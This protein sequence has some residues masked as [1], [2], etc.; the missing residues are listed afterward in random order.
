MPFLL[1]ILCVIALA[2]VQV[3]Y[4]GL[5]RPVFTVPAFFLL[6]L[7][8]VL[9]I[10][11]IWRKERASSVS[12]VGLVLVALLAGWL[13]WREMA[14]V[15]VW[16]GGV[17]LRL[18]LACTLSYFLFAAIILTSQARLIFVGMLCSLCLLQAIFALW[19]GLAPESVWQMPWLSE[20][21]RLWY[22]DRFVGR[23]RG[24]YLNGNHLSWLLNAGCLFAVALAIWGRIRI[25]W[26]I[27]FVLVG[28]VCF[29]ASL[30][31]ASRGGALSLVMG[32]FTLGLLS[33]SGLTV[34][35]KSSIR[36]LA[37]GLLLAG[38][39]GGVG[40][41]I[42]ANNQV[43]YDRWNLGLSDT[44]R[45]VVYE[46]GLRQAQIS[47]LLGTGPGSFIYHARQY[48][49]IFNQTD[50]VFAH[51]D[52]LQMAADFGFPALALL[53][54]VYLWHLGRAASSIAWMF[55]NM[56]AGSSSRQ[57]TSLAIQ[58]GAA[59]CLVAFGVH[60]WVDFN[61]QIP[62]NALLA[63][64]CLGVTANHGALRSAKVEPPRARWVFGVVSA[65]L[66]VALLY[67]IWQ[68]SIPEKK[69]LDAENA[70][71]RKSWMEARIRAL[72]G[73]GHDREHPGLLRAL[74]VASVELAKE[75]PLEDQPSLFK[76]AGQARQ[77]AMK[78]EPKNSDNVFD[79]A[80][81]L[82]QFDVR[83]QVMP[84]AVQGIVLS[85]QRANGY[86]LY[87]EILLREERFRMA[88]R[89]FL[90]GSSKPGASLW[91][92]RQRQVEEGVRRN[93]EW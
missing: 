34:V 40:F 60:S 65:F 90:M 61:M 77:A 12:W 93:T 16:M 3:L 75:R 82:L 79:Q 35:A 48:R 30:S 70:N 41:L 11:R 67:M 45:D 46:A 56:L 9:G 80:S 44:Y 63:A 59:S 72:E 32:I 54:L 20:Q 38:A 52:W 24:F 1:A 22:A 31:T 21:L 7:A 26:K 53:A 57:S 2:S 39:A 87:G 62:A 5:F 86:E 37:G 84:L 92:L 83:Q 18:T 50:D 4:G 36:K 55:W 69:W 73:M 64:M 6:G 25:Y 10:S 76:E 33:L 89:S 28:L 49:T 42:L 88:R 17:Y 74:A 81:L 19:Q 78:A 13:I 47:P 91:N 43:V 71:F 66:G 29:A 27:V 8:G 51:N 58:V 15:D 23:G 85:P 14:S 68:A